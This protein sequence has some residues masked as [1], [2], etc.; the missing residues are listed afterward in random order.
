MW[1]RGD[2][3]GGQREPTALSRGLRSQWLGPLEPLQP[4]ESWT[5][6]RKQQLSYLAHSRYGNVRF[7]QSPLRFILIS[8]SCQKY[9]FSEARGIQSIAALYYSEQCMN[10]CQQ[11]ISRPPRRNKRDIWTRKQEKNCL[12]ITYIT[13]YSLCIQQGRKMIYDEDSEGVQIYIFWHTHTHN[14]T[15]STSAVVYKS[16]LKVG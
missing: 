6:I 9:F 5:Q 8:F 11:V 14:P 4:G 12:Y 16:W 10:L 1:P 15:V 7:Q 2:A 3:L 13:L